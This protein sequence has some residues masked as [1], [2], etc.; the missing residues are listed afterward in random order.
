MNRNIVCRIFVQQLTNHR[1]LTGSTLKNNFQLLLLKINKQLQ[2]YA[3]INKQE[4]KTQKQ[5]FALTQTQ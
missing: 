3:Q 2:T 4:N 1:A 5:T